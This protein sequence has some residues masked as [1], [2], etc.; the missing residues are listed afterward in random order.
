MTSRP[1]LTILLLANLLV[2]CNLPRDQG[3]K[4]GVPFRFQDSFNH[5]G[6]ASV[7]MWRAA[8]DLQEVSQQSIWDWMSSAYPACGSNQAGIEAAVRHFTVSG[9]DAYW[10]H[11]DDTQYESMISR[12][13]TSMDNGVAVIA[14]VDFNHTGV[15][16]GGKWHRE[17]SYNIWDFV[18]FHDPARG[19]NRQYQATE[20]MRDWFCP[21]YWGSCDQILSISASG[22]WISNLALY[23]DKVVPAGGGFNPQG[24]WPPEI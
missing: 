2:G 6:A 4:I 11:G 22:D 21:A 24:D 15:L 16:N 18:Y 10:D 5:C 20:W 7:L 17:G 23:G 1:V 9:S 19:S 12:Q 14:V 13:I 8:D 3:I